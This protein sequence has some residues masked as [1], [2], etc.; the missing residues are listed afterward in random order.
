MTIKRRL[1]LFCMTVLLSSDWI[2]LFAYFLTFLFVPQQKDSF[3]LNDMR[4]NKHFKFLVNYPFKK[5]E[6]AVFMSSF[7]QLLHIV[8]IREVLFPLNLV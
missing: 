2:E 8:Y 4:V 6:K 5:K 3:I 1:I 7:S